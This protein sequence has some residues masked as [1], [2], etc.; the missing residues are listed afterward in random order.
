MT[1]EMNKRQVVAIAEMT[2]FHVKG[3]LIVAFE[4]SQIDLPWL[5]PKSDFQRL[6][7]WHLRQEVPGTILL[8]NCT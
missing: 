5:T 8:H 7:G 1:Y 3:F 6:E 4:M 2:N